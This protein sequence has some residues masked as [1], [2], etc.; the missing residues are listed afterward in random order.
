MDGLGPVRPT[1]QKVFLNPTDW[2]RD[3]RPKAQPS[4]SSPELEDEEE[5]EEPDTEQ[6]E[7]ERLD[8]EA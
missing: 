3:G 4:P 2:R 8:L 7:S 1:D 6:A 5:D